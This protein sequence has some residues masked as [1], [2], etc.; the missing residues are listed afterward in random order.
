MLLY[1]L[2]EWA[3]LTIHEVLVILLITYAH[4]IVFGGYE[5]AGFLSMAM[6]LL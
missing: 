2:I 4:A 5:V 1:V 6:N 3:V